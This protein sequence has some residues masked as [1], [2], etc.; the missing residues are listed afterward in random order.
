MCVCIYIYIHSSF[1]LALK[2]DLP[3]QFAS[4][5]RSIILS[6]VLSEYSFF[7]IKGFFFQVLDS[8]L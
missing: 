4:P 6:T 5:Q 8:S 1:D 3:V 2:S 7:L